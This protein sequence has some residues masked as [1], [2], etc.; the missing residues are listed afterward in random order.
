MLPSQYVESHEIEKIYNQIIS[1]QLKEEVVHTFG[2]EK[3]MLPCKIVDYINEPPTDAPASVVVQYANDEETDAE[4]TPKFTCLRFR[5]HQT[6]IY[7]DKILKWKIFKQKENVVDKI[8]NTTYMEFTQILMEFIFIHECYHVVQFKLLD[9][10]YPRYKLNSNYKNEIEREANLRTAAFLSEHYKDSPCKLDVI[11]TI[12]NVYDLIEEH[13]ED[14][15]LQN[16][17]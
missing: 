10:S 1:S 11:D 7:V 12:K 3:V 6:T 15:G 5:I 4:R 9:A 17:E 16:E 2:I 14:K 13:K 8:A